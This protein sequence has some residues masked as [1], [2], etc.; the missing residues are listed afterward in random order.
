MDAHPCSA[1]ENCVVH[2][3]RRGPPAG[4]GYAADSEWVEWGRMPSSAERPLT[5]GQ[6]SRQEYANSRRNEDEWLWGWDADQRSEVM[7]ITIPQSLPAGM[8]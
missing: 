7:S 6:E 3:H 4:Q 5:I 2:R 8:C 1:Y